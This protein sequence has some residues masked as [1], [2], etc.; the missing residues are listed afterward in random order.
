MDVIFIQEFKIETLIGVH[1]WE[2]R[3]PQTV[4]IN[5]EIA[6]PSARAAQS[7]ELGDTIDYG[8]VVGRVR[9]TLRA[10]HFPLLEAMAEELAR[11][12]L[13]EFGAPWAKVSVAKLGLFSGVKRIGVSIER[14]VK[15]EVSRERS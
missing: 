7:N 2:R 6:L 12:I 11:L 13:D 14:G 9:E 5:L 15:R 1:D 3:V 4:E 8:R 10:R